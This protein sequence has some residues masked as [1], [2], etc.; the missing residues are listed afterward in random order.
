MNPYRIESINNENYLHE[1]FEII[2]LHYLFPNLGPR[3]CWARTCVSTEFG[4]S[5]PSC[6]TNYTKNRQIHSVVA[7]Y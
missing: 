5:N 2:F 6:T 7:Y 1:R 4:Q 3:C